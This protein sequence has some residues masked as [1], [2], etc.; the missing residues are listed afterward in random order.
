MIKPSAWL[1]HVAEP[2]FLCGMWW[3]DALKSLSSGQETAKDNST[4]TSNK[5]CQNSF[6]LSNFIV[7][8]HRNTSAEAE[9]CHSLVFPVW[10]HIRLLCFNKQ[11]KV[12][13]VCCEN[14]QPRDC[15]LNQHDIIFSV[16]TCLGEVFFRRIR[17]V[18]ADS[19]GFNYC[20]PIKELVWWSK[21]NMLKD[22]YILEISLPALILTSAFMFKQCLV[23]LFVTHIFLFFSPTCPFCRPVLNVFQSLSFC[24]S[25]TN[26]NHLLCF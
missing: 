23:R 21:Q 13:L 22:I 24:H 4:A 12:L 18:F 1:Q 7:L 10:R 19:P 5:M 15:F 6:T 26:L 14:I 11:T 16:M 17:Q 20:V 2:V 9:E 3:W 25:W 8:I